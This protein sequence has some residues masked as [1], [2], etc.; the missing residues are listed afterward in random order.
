VTPAVARSLTPDTPR[1]PGDFTGVDARRL[2][3]QVRASL[4]ARAANGAGC[5]VAADEPLDDALGREADQADTE[6]KE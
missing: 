6:R 5:S 4:R 2:G 3:S 1:W